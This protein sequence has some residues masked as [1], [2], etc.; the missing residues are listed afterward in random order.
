MREGHPLSSDPKVKT[1]AVLGGTGR[2]GS[3][4]VLRWAQGGYRVLIGSR[5]AARAEA[6]ARELNAVIGEDVIRGLDN[7]EAAREADMV[8]L[9]V[10]YAAH[11]HILRSVKDVV[12][13]KILVDVTVPIQPPAIRTVYVPEGK[14]ASL[15]AQALLG[16]GVRVVT[17]FQN[18]SASHLP[19]LAHSVNCDVL[20]CGDDADAKNEVF[21]LVEAI[22]GMRAVDAG[23]LAN[24]VAVEALTP[25]L[26]YVNKRYKVAGA[27]I[28]ITGLE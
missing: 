19:D 20:V 15:E 26:L 25:V 11:E 2:E 1:I 4:L 24:A 3:G 27:G 13:G 22:A 16:D 18:V 21:Q 28:R 8:V 23:P 14:A 17:A 6:K 9:A 5:D 12:Q 7:V 10:P